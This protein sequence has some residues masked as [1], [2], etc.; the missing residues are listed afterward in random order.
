M[1]WTVLKIFFSSSFKVQLNFWNKLSLRLLWMSL[2][3]GKSSKTS[4]NVRRGRKTDQRD[5]REGPNE[6]FKERNKMSV[7]CDT[8]YF[9]KVYRS[10]QVRVPRIILK[11][12]YIQKLPQK[13]SYQSIYYRI[14]TKKYSH[15]V[16]IL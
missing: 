15:Y 14:H 3:G 2:L 4:R 13:R 16:L 12:L 9:K 10:L 11:C 7:I 8:E 6:I 1:K 5:V